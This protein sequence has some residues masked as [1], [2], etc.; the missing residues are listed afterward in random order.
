MIREGFIFI[1]RGNNYFV[2]VRN[3]VIVGDVEVFLVIDLI[4]FL[5]FFFIYFKFFRFFLIFILFVKYLIFM[6]WVVNLG[7]NRSL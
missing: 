6:Y 1:C 2:V 7:V 3:C 4:L 5:C